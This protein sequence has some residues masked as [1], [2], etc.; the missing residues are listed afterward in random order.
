MITRAE[1]IKS[2]QFFL[3]KPT[4]AEQIIALEEKT[5][6]YLPNQFAINQVPSF[7][8]GERKVSIGKIH[9]FYFLGIKRPDIDWK[10]QAF[11]NQSKCKE[12]F[13]QLPN[14]E[15]RDLAFWLNTMEDIERN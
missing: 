11:E 2:L 7:E 8:I 1:S 5:G 3:N 6:N 9:G 10:Y 14:I 12:F 13:I 4:L 15:E